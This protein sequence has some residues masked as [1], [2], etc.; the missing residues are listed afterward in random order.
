MHLY[1]ANPI[2]FVNR[3][4]SLLVKDCKMRSGIYEVLNVCV[5]RFKVDLLFRQEVP[6]EVL[7]PYN[8]VINTVLRQNSRTSAGS[9][10]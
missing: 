7:I 5:K 3:R 9:S 1:Y 10:A 2:F 6:R 4:E 8:Q